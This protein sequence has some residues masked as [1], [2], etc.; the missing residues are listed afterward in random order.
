MRYQWLWSL[1]DREV[2]E[3]LRLMKNM[4]SGGTSSVQGSSSRKEKILK[5]IKW[6]NSILWLLVRIRGGF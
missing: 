6:I 3:A 2:V 4:D 5:A 1:D